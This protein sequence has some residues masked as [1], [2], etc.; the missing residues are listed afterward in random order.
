MENRI[1]E[2]QLALFADRTSSATLRANQLRRI[3]PRWPTSCSSTSATGGGEPGSPAP[4]ATRYGCGC[5]RSAPTSRHRAP[6]LRGAVRAGARR[7]SVHHG[8]STFA[9]TARPGLTIGQAAA[10]VHDRRG[11][12]GPFGHGVLT[13]PILARAHVVAR[14]QTTAGA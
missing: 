2:Q 13:R 7:R 3:G 1:K 12:R 10:Y 5:S 8:R 9:R 6:H 4:N 11:A 14:V